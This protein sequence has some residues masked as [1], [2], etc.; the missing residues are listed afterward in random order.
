MKVFR[1]FLI[2]ILFSLISYSAKAQFA[3]GIPTFINTPYGNIPIPTYYHMPIAYWNLGNRPSTIITKDYYMIKL[4]NDSTIKVFG[5]LDLTDSI[6]A[7]M[8]KEKKKVTRKI[9][10]IETQYIVALGENNLHIAGNPNDSC[11]IFKQLDD[12][13]SLYSVVPR[14]GTEYSIFFSK[15]GNPELF[16]LNEANLLALVGDDDKLIEAIK[17]KNYVKAVKK[18]NSKLTQK[19]E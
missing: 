10:P 16:A 15:P 11:W 12:H 8:V 13:V 14:A 9:Y 4:K 2:F 5:E 19:K 7:L 18:Y 17:K 6:H 1:S 3:P